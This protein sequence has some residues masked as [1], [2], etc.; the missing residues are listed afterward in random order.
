MEDKSK[1]LATGTF[2]RTEGE[3]R[4]QR[5]DDEPRDGVQQQQQ[6]QRRQEGEEETKRQSEP[7]S[8][9]GEAGAGTAASIQEFVNEGEAGLL[10]FATP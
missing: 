6:Q 7:P 5:D 8:E 1:A 3:N 9:E 10:F 4:M 2:P